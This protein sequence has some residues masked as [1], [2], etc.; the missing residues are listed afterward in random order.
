VNDARIVQL[1]QAKPVIELR[2]RNIAEIGIRGALEDPLPGG[3]R[4]STSQNDRGWGRSS[5]RQ[6]TA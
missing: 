2:S 1:F 6:R 3:P 5:L 4:T